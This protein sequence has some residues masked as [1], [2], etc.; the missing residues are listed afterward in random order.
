MEGI[1]FQRM[2]NIDYVYWFW[3]AF[4][5]VLERVNGYLDEAQGLKKRESQIQLNVPTGTVPPPARFRPFYNSKLDQPPSSTAANGEASG[6]LV[7]GA[8]SENSPNLQK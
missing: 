5:Q 3:I 4:H 2:P 6:V 1:W 8:S 7:G